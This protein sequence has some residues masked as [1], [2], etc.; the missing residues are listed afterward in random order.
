L[1]AAYV[2]GLA[3]PSLAVPVS[4]GASHEQRAT[5]AAIDEVMA[6][7]GFEVGPPNRPQTFPC[8]S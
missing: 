4:P 1:L 5:T 8:S 2:A 7:P 6:V 3:L